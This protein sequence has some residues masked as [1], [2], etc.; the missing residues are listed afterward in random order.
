M[1]TSSIAIA[2]VL[3]AITAR[4]SAATSSYLA[5]GD[6]PDASKFLQTFPAPGSELNTYEVGVYNTTRTYENSKKK[7]QRRRWNLAVS[8]N[9]TDNTSL[10]ADFSC[11]LGASLTPQNAPHLAKVISRSRQDLAAVTAGAKSFFH[12]ARPFVGNSADTCVA[13]DSVGPDASYPS[14]HASISWMIA[15]ELAE[16]APAQSTTIMARARAFGESRVVCGMHWPSDIEAG[17][18]TGAAVY[19]ALQSNFSFRNNMQAAQSDIANVLA[20]PTPPDAKRCEIESAA[21]AKQPW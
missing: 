14:A 7:A 10:L 3:L 21:A 13:R 11:A 2:F 19:G 1:R 4:G 17:R 9:S 6:R 16:L 20:N 5:A 8:D 18:S 12:R 15:L